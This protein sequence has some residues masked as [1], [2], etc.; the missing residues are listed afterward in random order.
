MRFVL[1]VI[2][3]ICLVIPSYAEWTATLE[4]SKVVVEGGG[5]SYS[6][7][8]P[9]CCFYDGEDLDRIEF[10]DWN[11]DPTGVTIDVS[12]HSWI[13]WFGIDGDYV[14][15]TTINDSFITTRFAMYDRN[16][17][18]VLEWTERDSLSDDAI[19]VPCGSGRVVRSKNV[20]NGID[21]VVVFESDGSPVCSVLVDSLFAPWLSPDGYRLYIIRGCGKSPYLDCMKPIPPNFPHEEIQVFDVD[22]CV[23]LH[24][25][26]RAPRVHT[27]IAHDA[28]VVAMWIDGQTKIYSGGVFQ[29]SVGSVGAINISANGEY[30]AGLMSSPDRITAFN[31]DRMTRMWAIPDSVDEGEQR[32]LPKIADNGVTIY[33]RDLVHGG[34]GASL[35]D[36]DG[37]VFFKIDFSEIPDYYL[38]GDGSFC[39]FEDRVDNIVSFYRL[40]SNL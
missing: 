23:E 33:G 17:T 4:W 2:A 21:E 32:L 37:N 3:V 9:F 1:I 19:V 40:S 6:D 36:P 24:T 10:F 28:D 8:G 7:E 27:R 29:G 25:L 22:S 16:G 31:L 30:L 39:V 12:G 26:P 20:G 15:V 14:G 35:V 13:N 18:I 34:Y 11:G 5:L 38:S